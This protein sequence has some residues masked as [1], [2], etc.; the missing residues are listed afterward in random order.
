M[1]ECVPILSIRENSRTSATLAAGIVCNMYY[2]TLHVNDLYIISIKQEKS[3]K[4][5]AYR[6]G[7]IGF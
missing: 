6:H 2:S 1:W 4:T 3:I 7:F 5:C